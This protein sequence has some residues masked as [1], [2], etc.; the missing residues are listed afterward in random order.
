MGAIPQLVQA[1]AA[2]RGSVWMIRDDR[3]H[4]FSNF[5][6]SDAPSR[7]GKGD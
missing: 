1:E 4:P 5:G 3:E 2:C 7:N 6:S